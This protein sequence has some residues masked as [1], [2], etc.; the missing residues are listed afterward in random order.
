MTLS[1]REL[2]ELVA[3]RK[4]LLSEIRRFEERYGMSSAEF[5]ESWREGL[6]PEPEDPEVHGDFL[7]WEALIEELREVG[8]R[9]TSVGG[10]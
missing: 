1:L 5:I 2:E 9:L 3:R 6:I 8:E 7:A 10:R 4:W